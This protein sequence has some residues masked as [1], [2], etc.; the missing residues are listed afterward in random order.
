MPTSDHQ[1]VGHTLTSLQVMKV[2]KLAKLEL[3]PEQVEDYRVKLG[4]VLGYIDRL[5]ALNLE[6]VEP[7]TTPFDPGNRLAEDTP[8]PSLPTETLMRMAPE[9][10]PPFIVV[11]KVLDE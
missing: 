11:P 6:G 2:A 3:S 7:M 4:S 10:D 5:R 8:E 1:S 9:K